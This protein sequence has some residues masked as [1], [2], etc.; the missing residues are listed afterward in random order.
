[1]STKTQK[2]TNSRKENE[3]FTDIDFNKCQICDAPDKSGYGICDRCCEDMGARMLQRLGPDFF[4][5]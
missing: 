3:E 2:K 4:K 5:M 1:M